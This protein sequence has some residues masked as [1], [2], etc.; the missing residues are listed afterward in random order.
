MRKSWFHVGVVVLGVMTVWLSGRPS[1]AAL[2]G[3][4]KFDGNLQD[5]SGLGS[6]GTFYGGTAVYAADRNG[7]PNSAIQF[8]GTDDRVVFGAYGP[9]QHQFR[10]RRMDPNFRYPPN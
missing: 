3:Y 5:S 9:G 1:E 4:F 10:L 6:H 2:V 8:D 7:N